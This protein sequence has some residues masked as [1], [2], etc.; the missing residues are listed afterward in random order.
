M[1][2]QNYRS[3]NKIRPKQKKENKMDYLK[4]EK[5]VSSHRLNLS[6]HQTL[7]FHDPVR[8]L[9]FKFLVR[10]PDSQLVSI[11]PCGTRTKWLSENVLHFFIQGVGT[12]ISATLRPL[13]NVRDKSNTANV[14]TKSVYGCPR[15]SFP[16]LKWT[17]QFF[18]NT[19][20]RMASYDWCS[21]LVIHEIYIVP[22]TKFFR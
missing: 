15:F 3:R 14:S 17:L 12:R 9:Q 4:I 2:I 20:N 7:L 22:L 5:K 13:R 10:L 19:E 18:G 6:P 11:V 1:N 16:E 21:Q 8:P